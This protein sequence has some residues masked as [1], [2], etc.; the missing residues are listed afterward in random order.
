VT[1]EI[2][3]FF[4]VRRSSASIGN[5]AEVPFVRSA[6]ATLP[7]LSM[8]TLNMVKHRARGKRPS[9]GRVRS[10]HGGGLIGRPRGAAR[11]MEPAAG[12]I[13]P[14]TLICPV[15]RQRRPQKAALPQNQG[16]VQPR[17]GG[18]CA[19]MER[20]WWIWGRSARGPSR[21]VTKFKRIVVKFPMQAN[22]ELL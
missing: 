10:R 15:A 14:F 16:D 19:T 11:S 12:L 2:V 20:I 9:G 18:V 3:A 1:I 21:P 7:T 6:R 8:A 4:A 22:R 17:Q 13:L 5:V